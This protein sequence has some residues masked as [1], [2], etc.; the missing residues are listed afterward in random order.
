MF[1]IQSLQSISH[2]VAVLK[3]IIHRDQVLPGG[4]A[5]SV[6]AVRVW[7]VVV[8]KVLKYRYQVAVGC[9]LVGEGVFASKQLA[10]PFVYKLPLDDQTG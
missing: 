3:Q 6:E 1:E 2:H 4:V 5:A 7:Q 9:D 8:G 10:L